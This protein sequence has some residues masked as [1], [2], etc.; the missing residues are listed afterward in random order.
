M[1]PTDDPESIWNDT[2]KLKLETSSHNF[3]LNNHRAIKKLY[4]GCCTTLIKYSDE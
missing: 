2:F 3:L 4:I 1:K